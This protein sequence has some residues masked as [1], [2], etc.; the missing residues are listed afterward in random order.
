MKF[1]GPLRVRRLMP[2]RGRITFL[3]RHL[4]PSKKF[5]CAPARVW[6]RLRGLP[7]AG[8][9]PPRRFHPTPDSR[10]AFSE[11]S[12]PDTKVTYTSAGRPLPEVPAGEESS[13]TGVAAGRAPHEAVHLRPLDGRRVGA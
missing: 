12:C 2:L 9:N 11:G 10:R 13:L 7:D 8:A 1:F 3:N 5:S 6:C 4:G